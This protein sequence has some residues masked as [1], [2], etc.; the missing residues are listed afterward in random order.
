MARRV[1]SRAKGS[2]FE[3]VVCKSFESWSGYEFS[4]TPAS[5]GLRWKKTD[6]ISSDVVCSDPKH[7]RK[8]PFS[9]EV[10]N[11][12]NIKFEHLLLGNKTC[13]IHDFW[14]QATEDA[15]RAKKL[16]VLIMRYNSMPKGEAFFVIGFNTALDLYI[17]VNYPNLINM[18]VQTGDIQISVYMFKEIQKE[19]DYQLL[20]K[21]A[22]K[23]LK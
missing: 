2:R 4:R 16:P 12:Q 5:G 3:R 15:N 18:T 13:K 22:R 6:N 19:V 10:K 17:K 8:F 9:V 23:L 1:N 20:Y 21:Y 14:E 11:Y 7:S